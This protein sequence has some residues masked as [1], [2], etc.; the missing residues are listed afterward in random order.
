MPVPVP[1]PVGPPVDELLLEVTTT[2]TPGFEKGSRP[3][4]SA[5]GWGAV[6]GVL[7]GVVL[8][9]GEPAGGGNDGSASSP[10]PPL[11]G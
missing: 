8:G 7:L 2:N 4:N 10:P 11:A 1:L 9:G 5:T 3:V 6:V